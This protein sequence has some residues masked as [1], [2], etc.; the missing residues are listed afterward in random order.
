[1]TAARRCKALTDLGL[2]PQAVQG[3]WATFSRSWCC[4]TDIEA[5]D[6]TTLYLAR[7]VTV[8]LLLL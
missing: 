7:K 6:V 8:T 4:C 3:L 2:T 5:S 1:M